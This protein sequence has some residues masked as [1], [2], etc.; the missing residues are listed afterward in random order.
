MK[1]YFKNFSFRISHFSF[2]RAFT[3]IELLITISLMSILM[4]SSVPAFFSY[5]K[6]QSFQTGISDIIALLNKAKSRSLSQVKPPDCNG[7]KLQGYQVV[8]TLSGS[9]YQLEALCDN[10]RYPIEKKNLPTKITF[11]AT[12]TAIVFFNASTGTLSSPVNV[13]VAGYNKSKTINIDGV[14]TISIQ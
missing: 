2:Q 13:I 6:S 14:G 5:T 10:N 8:L 9:S 7:L 1:K 11:A 12:S 4:L 3:L